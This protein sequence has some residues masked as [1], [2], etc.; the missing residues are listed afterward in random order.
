MSEN[1]QCKNCGSEEIFEDPSQGTDIC[2]DCGTIYGSIMD[3]SDSNFMIGNNEAF[4]AQRCGGRGINELCP[5]AGKD[6][7]MW[8]IHSSC[9]NIIRWG[10]I[11]YQDRRILEIKKRIDEIAASH[12]SPAIMEETI[13]LTKACRK[14][15]SGR[16][17]MD[18]PLGAASNYYCCNAKGI[19]VSCDEIRKLYKLTDTAQ[20]KRFN[21]AMCIVEQVLAEKKYIIQ[22]KSDDGFID[23]SGVQMA[24]QICNNLGF[25]KY[26]TDSV[27]VIL[28]KFYEK[29]ILQ[30][31]IVKI[32]VG[33]VIY[34]VAKNGMNDDSVTMDA[35]IKEIGT[36]STTAINRIYATL[37]NVHSTGMMKYINQKKERY[38]VSTPTTIPKAKSI[39]GKEKKSSS[40]YYSSS[41]S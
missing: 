35:I 38:N 21:E 9:R 8:N 19:P 18:I 30:N 2:N 24:M 41:D 13:H 32:K 16:K 3:H 34:F 36:S 23:N 12:F 7:R 11:T 26:A 6:L 31:V 28:Y 5:S 39:K 10:S 4:I 33:A 29:N 37:C 27:S 15:R 17:N 22:I 14:H 1:I 25:P 40:E 20:I